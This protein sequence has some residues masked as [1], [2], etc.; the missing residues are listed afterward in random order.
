MFFSVLFVLK[1][2]IFV[3]V[4]WIVL[5]VCGLWFEC[6]V[7]LCIEKVLKLIS[8][9]ELLFLRVFEI[10]LMNEFSVWFVVVL[11]MLVLVVIWLINWDLFI[12]L[13]F[14][15]VIIKSDYF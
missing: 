14:F 12:I 11:E 15:I 1:E 2:G 7:C 4:I 10:V 5:L 9:I 8:V 3:V 6:V 13:F